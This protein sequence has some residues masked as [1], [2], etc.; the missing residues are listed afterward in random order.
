MVT[1]AKVL[2]LLRSGESFESAARRLGVPAGQA[3]MIATGIPADFGDS[4][5]PEDYGREGLILG[6]SQA[7]LGVPH[8]NPNRPDDKPEVMAWVRDRARTQM[9][10]STAPDGEEQK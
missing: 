10:A 7:L 9:Q 3:Y 2:E 5:G 8:H 6:G 4:L 1:R